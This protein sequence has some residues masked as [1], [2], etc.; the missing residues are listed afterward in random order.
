[1][2]LTCR[3][4]AVCRAAG[5]GQADGDSVQFSAKAQHLTEEADEVVVE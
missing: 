5:E 3:P 1:M 2:G 4:C